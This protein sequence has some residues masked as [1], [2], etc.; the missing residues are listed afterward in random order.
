MPS[1]RVREGPLDTSSKWSSYTVGLCSVLSLEPST[2]TSQQLLTYYEPTKYSN[3][4]SSKLVGCCARLFSSENWGVEAL[5]PWRAT[6]SAVFPA[7]RVFQDLLTSWIGSGWTLYCC[8]LLV[9]CMQIL[10]NILS[11]GLSRTSVAIF[12]PLLC[13]LLDLFAPLSSN[14]S[15][16]CCSF[17]TLIHIGGG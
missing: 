2:K 14:L 4:Y 13:D 10:Y 6:W 11:L 12:A 1:S 9:Y 3:I 17:P 16:I 15:D 5:Q 7:A 8:C